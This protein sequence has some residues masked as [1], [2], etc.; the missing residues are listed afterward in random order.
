MKF[1]ICKDKSK[2][3][4]K[5]T[6]ESYGEWSF[7]RDTKVKMWVG[8]DHMVLYC[9]YLIEGDI[10]EACKN[11]S[12]NDENGNFFAVKLTKTD[13]EIS[14]DYFQNHKLFVAGKY[15]IEIT[16]Y[17]PYMTINL[18][19]VV[20]KK[21]TYDEYEREIMPKESET[22]YGHINSFVPPYDYVQDSKDTLAQ[23]HWNSIDDLTDYIHQCMLS[24]SHVINQNYSN[25]VCSLSEGIDSAVQS[26]YFKDAPQYLYDYYPC[27]AGSIHKKL[28]K[29]AQAN[30]PN[31][32]HYTFLQ[33]DNKEECFKQLV[34]STCRWNSILPTC[35]QIV[36][37]GAN[38]DIILY[39]VNG[40]EMFI[41]DLIPHLLVLS[42][43]Y[44][45]KDTEIMCENI[46]KD[47]ESKK[48]QYGATYSTPS[49]E[50]WRTSETY[51]RQFFKK[52]FKTET[53]EKWYLYKK[54]RE[55]FEHALLMY[56]TP[57]LYT[58]VI[59]G[60]NDIM[61]SSLYNDRRIYHEFFKM[62][63]HFIEGDAMDAKIQKKILDKYDY[64]C[65][66]PSNDILIADYDELYNHTYEATIDHDL[67]Q[68]I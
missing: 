23:E 36:D 46:E 11:F 66:A 25:V 27:D 57:K 61:C 14:L 33:K 55:E 16:N 22:F 38:P 49:E 43:K 63:N 67:E 10:N 4:K 35:K 26:L 65:I 52:Y 13:Y 34:D 2:F 5:Q 6:V 17:L 40:E 1:F 18:T 9:G 50:N 12:F 60:N 28:I 44:Y 62:Q 48:G 58:R 7:I 45:D 24:H 8:P 53:K 54:D 31:T 19:D 56:T 32:H 21:L 37:V 29:V 59:S 3:T 68:N 41:R 47:I 30:F 42:L 39:G 15:G 20:R 51:V 64:E